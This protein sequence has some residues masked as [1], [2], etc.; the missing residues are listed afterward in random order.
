VKGFEIFIK[1]LNS[2]KI[3]KKWFKVVKIDNLIIGL[4]FWEII[5]KYYFV[6]LTKIYLIR[7]LVL[8]FDNYA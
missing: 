7:P 6:I 8:V 3:V 5:K 4:L 2:L 1:K